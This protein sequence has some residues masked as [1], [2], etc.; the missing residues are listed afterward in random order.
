MPSRQILANRPAN[1]VQDQASLK[2]LLSTEN[3]S[4]TGLRLAGLDLKGAQL[5]HRDLSCVDL[6]HADLR[7]AN[8]VGCRMHNA[9]LH[10]ANLEGAEFMGAD[11][12]GANLSEAQAALGGF[13]RVNLTDANCFGI[14]LE[15]ATLTEAVLTGAD[16]R[17]ANLCRARMR[18]A[19]LQRA[20]FLKSKLLDVD[21]EGADVHETCFVEADLRRARLRGLRRFANAHFFHADVREI[22]FSGAYL[23]RRQILDENY[24]LEFRSQ[25]RAAMVVYWIW[26]ATSDC[27]RSILRWATWTVV[28]WL[29]FGA[30]YELCALDYGAHRTLISPFYFSL[31]TLTTL[32]Y[33]DVVPASPAAQVVVMAEVVLGYV[34]L[35]GLLTIISS[36]MGRRSD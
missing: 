4:L 32:G 5:S 15:G 14:N 31:V 36:K 26:W 19:R 34:M 20:N 18:D 35:G 23:L 10:G 2:R 17:I 27:G 8:L 13:G 25:S 11:L 30:A 29:A 12:H 6:S 22:D 3:A 9:I 21:L 7:G 28:V 33:G 16:L 24:L 1:D